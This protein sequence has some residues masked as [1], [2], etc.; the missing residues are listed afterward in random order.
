MTKYMKKH[1]Y[2]VENNIYDAQKEIL[3]SLYE[4]LNEDGRSKLIEHG[5]LLV[6][7]GQYTHDLDYIKPSHA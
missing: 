4:K 6:S 7:S 3:I 5:Q 2:K 1:G